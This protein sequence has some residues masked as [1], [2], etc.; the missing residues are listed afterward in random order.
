MAGNSQLFRA[1]IGFKMV[2]KAIKRK[3]KERLVPENS[4]LI[5]KI[6]IMKVVVKDMF[7]LYSHSMLNR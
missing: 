1:K 4:I 2:A 5:S 3:Q 7:D 6:E